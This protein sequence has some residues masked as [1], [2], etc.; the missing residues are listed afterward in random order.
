MEM[1]TRGA[2]NEEG[3]VDSGKSI[4]NEGG[5]QA[6]ETR[7]MATVM[8]TMWAMATST[9]LVGNKEGKGTGSKSNG[10]GNEGG[11]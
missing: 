2:C 1:A 6:T 7:E 10:D 3:N 4:D 11:R 8:F 9:R 5:K